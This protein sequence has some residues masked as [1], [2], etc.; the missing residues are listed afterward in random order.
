MVESIIR[1]FKSLDFLK[2]IVLAVAMLIPVFLSIYILE[3]IHVGFSIALGVLFCSPTDVPGSNK[4][5]FFGTLIATFLSFGL[6]LLFGSVANILWLLLPLLV[7]SVF[8][9]SYISVFG[10]RASLI[11]FVGL[12]AI[13]LKFYSRLFTSKFAA[14]CLIN[15]I[16]RIVVFIAYLFKVDFV[17][18]NSGRSIVCKNP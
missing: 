2:G 17:S 5:V 10:F 1:F 18:K 6:T 12:L 11:S 16:G 9:V 4:H 13:V 8:L 3:D 15:C 7:V 14:A